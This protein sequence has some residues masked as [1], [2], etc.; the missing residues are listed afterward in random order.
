M[1]KK[2]NKKLFLI[3]IILLSIL[4]FS[5]YSFA[6][7]SKIIAG[8]IVQTSCVLA[9]QKAGT[10]TGIVT[11]APPGIDCGTNC[12]YVFP[13]GTEIILY[14]VADPGSVFIGFTGAGCS[15]SPCTFTLSN[16]TTI[17]ATF[18]TNVHA[19]QYLFIG[20]TGQTF[21]RLHLDDFNTVDTLVTGVVGDSGYGSAVDLARRLVIFTGGIYAVFIDMD[22]FTV[23]GRTSLLQAGDSSVYGSP[24]VDTEGGYVY[25]NKETTN[26]CSSSCSKTMKINLTTFTIDA[27]ILFDLNVDKRIV[28][29]LWHGPT[30]QD[31]T[32]LYFGAHMV[33]GLGCGNNTHGWT[34]ID[35]AT[36]NHAGVICNGGAGAVVSGGNTGQE[37]TDLLGNK[38]MTIFDSLNPS[39][40]WKWDSA[41]A[42]VGT[43]SLPIGSYNPSA[44]QNMDVTG[45]YLFVATDQGGA[46]VPNISRIDTVTFLV[47][48]TVNTGAGTSNPHGSSYDS[49]RDYLYVTHGTGGTG[50]ITRISGNPFV[51]V[52]EKVMAVTVIA[53]Q[54]D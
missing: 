6:G 41:W 27:E 43:L 12:D 28:A 4:Y 8:N 14:A 42:W 51:V 18:S 10:G 9:I 40:V 36:F 37:L 31:N 47:D 33:A 38:Y 44:P 49:I 19:N 11:S 30:S 53:C 48:G 2:M 24:L 32:F 21:Y 25:I 22:T 46:S 13:C 52:D 15:T 20:S 17:I 3:S 23:T 34:K 54:V 50:A 29:D 35:K 39:K 45:Q 5:S 16:S 1:M 7:I 26:G